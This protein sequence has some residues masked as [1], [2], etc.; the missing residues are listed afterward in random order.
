MKTRRKIT[1]R[2]RRDGAGLLYASENSE[3][4]ILT[5]ISGGQYAVAE[6]V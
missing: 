4:V 6:L 3:G 2:H 5:E 1:L